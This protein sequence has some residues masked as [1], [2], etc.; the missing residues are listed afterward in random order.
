[1]FNLIYSVA[2]APSPAN[3]VPYYSGIGRH[4][5]K[6]SW[7]KYYTDVIAGYPVDTNDVIVLTFSE[8]YQVPNKV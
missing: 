2:S 8:P 5:V 3:S 1:M 4:Y 7:G 6:D